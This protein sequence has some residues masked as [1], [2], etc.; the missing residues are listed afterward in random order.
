MIA[1]NWDA[2]VIDYCASKHNMHEV[3]LLELKIYSSV[4]RIFIVAKIPGL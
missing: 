3:D 4:F 2:G 1:T